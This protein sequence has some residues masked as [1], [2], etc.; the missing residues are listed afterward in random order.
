MPSLPPEHA[1]RTRAHR[2]IANCTFQGAHLHFLLR[3]NTTSGT[4]MSDMYTM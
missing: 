2:Y 3:I 4:V 1:V